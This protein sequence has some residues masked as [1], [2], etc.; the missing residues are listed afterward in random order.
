MN[1]TREEKNERER[2][3]LPLFVGILGLKMQ[4]I[5]FFSSF[6]FFNGSLLM[7]GKWAKWTQV[8]DSAQPNAEA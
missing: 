4:G 3:E 6:F 7:R 5:V 1:Q 2:M 8:A